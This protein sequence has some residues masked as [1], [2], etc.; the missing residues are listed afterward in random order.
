MSF[1]MVIFK[2]VSIYAP[3]T[4][5]AGIQMHSNMEYNNIYY[6]QLNEKIF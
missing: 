6:W 3:N 2:A 5:K 1:D 4:T